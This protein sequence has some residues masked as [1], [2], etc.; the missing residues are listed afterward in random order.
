M[1]FAERI[2]DIVENVRIAYGDVY[3]AYGHPQEVFNML[4]KKGASEE[5]RYK[6][7]PLVALML[8]N[9]TKESNVKGQITMSDFEIILITSTNVNYLASDRYADTF[10]NT[11]QPLY[12]TLMAQVKAS[13]LV[14]SSE[15]YTHSKFDILYW[16]NQEYRGL[17]VGNDALDAIMIKDLELNLAG[18]SSEYTYI[19]TEDDKFIITEG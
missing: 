6:R 15:H 19:M 17:R 5:Y 13:K 11:L 18:C 8:Y 16:G 7:F 4:S 14:T 12:D 3:F 9:T 10:A 1:T 2:E